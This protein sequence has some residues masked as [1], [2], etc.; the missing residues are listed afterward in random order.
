MVAETLLREKQEASPSP[1]ELLLLQV[2]T[3]MQRVSE[4]AVILIPYP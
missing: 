3:P 2:A 1:V 4:K